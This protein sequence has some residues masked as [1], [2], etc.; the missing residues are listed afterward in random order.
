MVER[1]LFEPLFANRAI[2]KK[3]NKRVGHLEMEEYVVG[4]GLVWIYRSRGQGLGRILGC[5][6]GWQ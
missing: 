5:W 6:G 4:G 3:G 2:G 1:D